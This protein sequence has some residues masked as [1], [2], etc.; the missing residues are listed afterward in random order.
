MNGILSNTIGVIN[1]FSSF[2]LSVIQALVFEK[3]NF[4]GEYIEVD[5]DVYNLEEVEEEGDK[6]VKR[7][8]LSAVG[9]LKILGGL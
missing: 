2:S 9:S 6:P 8:T 7:T 4:E 5:S 3:P 1:S